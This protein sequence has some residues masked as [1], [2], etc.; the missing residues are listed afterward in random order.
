MKFNRQ[1]PGHY[2]A[3]AEKIEIKKGIGVN[4]DNKMKERNL[5]DLKAIKEAKEK[6]K[7]EI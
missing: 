5:A 2:I 1:A 7:K 3:T 4:M 6:A